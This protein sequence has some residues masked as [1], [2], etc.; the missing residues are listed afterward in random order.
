MLYSSV[1]TKLVVTLADALDAGRHRPPQL[2]HPGD[3]PRLGRTTKWRR[4]ER[5]RHCRLANRCRD[6]PVRSVNSV[7]EYAGMQRASKEPGKNLLQALTMGHKIQKV[8][9][10]GDERL[11]CRCAIVVIFIFWWRPLPCSLPA[12]LL[13]L[14]IPCPLSAVYCLVFTVDCTNT[15]PAVSG[16]H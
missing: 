1:V 10:A 13:L 15:E 16:A 4:R 9:R 7:L 14:C 11:L 2:I 8:T 3:T 12:R 6:L 5:V